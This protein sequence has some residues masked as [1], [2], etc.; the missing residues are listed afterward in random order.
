MIYDI[1]GFVI[2]VVLCLALVVFLRALTCKMMTGAWP[3]QSRESADM[4]DY[5]NR[6]T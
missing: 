4:M 1:I 2:A 5:L 3:H 6:N